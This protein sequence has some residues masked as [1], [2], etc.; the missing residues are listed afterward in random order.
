MY[1]NKT[2]AL[3]KECSEAYMRLISKG[4]RGK[5][6][7]RRKF[8][9]LTSDTFCLILKFIAHGCLLLYM[10]IELTLLGFINITTDQVN[11]AFDVSADSRNLI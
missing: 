6:N 8:L 5:C 10:R 3:E 1:S 2:G 7:W 9:T 11:Y 4:D